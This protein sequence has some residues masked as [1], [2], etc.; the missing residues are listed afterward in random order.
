MKT[1]NAFLISA[2]SLSVLWVV[3][4]LLALFRVFDFSGVINT[5]FNYIVAFG[6]VVACLFIYTLSLFIENK[7]ML[8]V[9]VW[10]SCSFY[11]AF[12]IFT[13]VYYFFGLYDN[14][15][16][17]LLFYAALSVLISILS[18]SIYYNCLKDDQGLLK[19]KIGFTGFILFCISTAIC[20]V[21]ELVVIFFKFC[22]NTNINLTIHTLTTFG[23]L[24]LGAT[25]FAVAFYYSIA[26][27]KKFV[28]SCLIKT[29]LPQAS[30]QQPSQEVTKNKNNS[31]NQKPR[32]KRH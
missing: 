3:L 27:K 29:K 32:Q 1:K 23:I 14:M 15:I 24:L 4:L 30:T 6:I 5:N 11:A 9:P 26:G 17:N 8:D 28:N 22:A 19:N 20:V 13:N 16:T 12:F 21:F 10:I 25:V 7:K 18:I 31:G 2:L